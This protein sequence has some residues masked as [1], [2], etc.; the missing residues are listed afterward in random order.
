MKTN[1]GKGFACHIMSTG[2][3]LLADILPT[4]II[5]L[6][7]VQ[8]VS[9]MRGIGVFISRSSAVI[10]RIKKLYI[11]VIM[12][13]CILMFCLLEVAYTF[14]PNIWIILIVIF[15]EGLCGGSV[16]VNCLLHD[17]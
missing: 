2:V 4:L 7:V 9:I 5:K 13:W 12:Q 16:Y 10:F 15:F 17:I 14:A 6:T 8:I 1:E 3:V 11:P